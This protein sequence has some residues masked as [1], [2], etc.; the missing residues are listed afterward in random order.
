MNKIRI[1]ETTTFVGEEIKVFKKDFEIYEHANGYYSI[2]LK[3]SHGGN[4]IWGGDPAWECC[5]RKDLAQAIF[6]EW[7]GVLYYDSYYGYG[8]SK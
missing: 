5:Y 8:I 6:K 4:N 2:S 3:D 1:E 7:N